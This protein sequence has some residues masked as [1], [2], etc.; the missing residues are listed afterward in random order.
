MRELLFL[1]IF[2]TALNVNSINSQTTSSCHDAY[3]CMFMSISNISST[4]IECYG[5]FSCSETTKLE[6]VDN[7]FI[8]CYGSFSCY[9]SNLI[10]SNNHIYCMFCFT[11]FRWLS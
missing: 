10:T 2:A 3:S 4:N 9:K 8:Y 5:Y 11:N 7:Q 1:A 6:I